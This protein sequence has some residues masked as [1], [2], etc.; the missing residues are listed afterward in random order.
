MYRMYWCWIMKITWRRNGKRQKKTGSKIV[1]TR[2]CIAKSN[3]ATFIYTIKIFYFDFWRVPHSSDLCMKRYTWNRK[4]NDLLY[5]LFCAIFI[6]FVFS[7]WNIRVI[8]ITFFS[9]SIHFIHKLY[10]VLYIFELNLN[11]NNENFAIEMD[12]LC[13]WML[14][15]EK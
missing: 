4:W 15:N 9:S 10:I 13:Y 1:D 12:S 5:S 7:F 3:F 11:S 2:Y 8:F 14:E 6:T